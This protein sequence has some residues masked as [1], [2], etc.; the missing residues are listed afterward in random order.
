MSLLHLVRHGQA[1]AGTDNYDRLSEIGKRQSEILGQWW[2]SHA[3]DPQAAFH[4]SLT[5][6]QDTAALSLSALD[7]PPSMKEAI[8]LNEYDHRVIESHFSSELDNYTPEAMSFDN[9]LQVMSRW[10]DQPADSST[11]H[12]ESWQEFRARGLDT[13]RAHTKPDSKDTAVFFTSGGVIATVLSSAGGFAT[14]QLP[15]FT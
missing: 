14:H 15:A 12:F 4:G 9:Y 13:L 2:S 8:G 3:I 7:K 10:R 5:R 1:S 6:Q 11:G